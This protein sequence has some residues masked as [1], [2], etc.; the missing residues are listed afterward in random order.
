MKNVREPLKKGIAKTPLIMQMEATECGAACLT[1]I[2]SYY[3]YWAPLEQIRYDCGVSRDGAN[4]ANVI[5]TARRYGLEADGYRYKLETLIKKAEFPCVIFWHFNHFIVL[6]G[7]RHGQVYLN[8]PSQG[9]CVMPLEEFAEGYSGVCLFLHPGEGFEPKGKRKSIAVFVLE[10]FNGRTFDLMLLIGITVIV[11]LLGFIQPGFSRMFMDKL[12]DKPDTVWLKPF[13]IFFS[14]FCLLQIIMQLFQ[15]IIR[16]RINEKLDILGNSAYMWHILR[17]PVPFFDNRVTGDIAQRKNEN[18]DVSKVLVNTIAPLGINACMIVFYLVVM[19]RYSFILSFIGLVSIGLKILV[20]GHISKKRM[21]IARVQ[22]RDYGN[23][24]SATL[25]GISIIET[26]KAAGA[27]NGYFG[28]W[29]GYQAGSNAQTQKYTLLDARLG[30]VPTILGHFCDVLVLGGGIYLAMLGEW[31]LGMIT[32]FQQI[33]AL[34]MAPAND[35]ITG[36]QTIQETRTSMERLD[37]VMKTEALS[38]DEEVPGED[39]AKLSGRISIKNLTFGYSKLADPLIRDFNLEIHP[40]QSVAVVGASGSGKSTLTKLISGLYKQWSGTIEYD[41]KKIEDI[42][43]YIFTASIATVDQEIRLQEDTIA[44]NIR[45]GNVAIEDYEIIMAARD[46]CIHEDILKRNLGY[47]DRLIDGGKDLSGGQRQRLE[48]ARALA[49]EP[50]IL[51]L[52]E[53]TSALDA[54]TE[55]RV[56]QAIRNRGITTIIIAH[57]LSTIRDSDLIIVLDHGNIVEQGTHD[58]LVDKKGYYYKLVSTD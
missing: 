44:N 32:A 14:V 3:G 9:S 53:G 11:A 30:L 7:I 5:K 12:L 49:Q 52:D 27:E 51:I 2:L 37:D 6:N 16:L 50:S 4:A 21:N 43:R 29:A 8:D 34:F 35:F 54:E 24:V 58:E 13:M 56:M 39:A 55:F 25:N 41:G 20:A 33:L 18:A 48:I 17:L 36:I 46:A 38:W 15:V 57:R 45:F 28:K 42:N 40:G 23:L 1:M 47:S 31:T 19:V 26:I 10:R 22:K